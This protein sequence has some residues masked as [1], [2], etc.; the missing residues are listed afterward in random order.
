MWTHKTAYSQN[1][2]DADCFSNKMHLATLHN[3]YI[4][5]IWLVI[6]DCAVNRQ[7]FKLTK[8]L[9]ELTFVKKNCW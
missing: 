4:Y 1:K 9:V 2:N 8:K 5:V 6:Y 3:S 7:K